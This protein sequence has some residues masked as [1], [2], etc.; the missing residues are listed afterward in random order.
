[1]SANKSFRI[2]CA[3]AA[4][5]AAGATSAWA[6]TSARE[7]ALNGVW[8]PA[9]AAG[10]ALLDVDGK[11]PPLNDAGKK[12][13]EQRS[14][15]LAKG[16]TSYD[17]SKKCKP[18]GFPRSLWDGSPFDLQVQPKLVFF[19]YTWN[20]NHRTA[21]FRDKLP[22]VQ[23]ARYYGLSAAHWDGNTLV[24]DSEGFNG[25]TLLDTKGLPHSEDMTL[26]ERYEPSADDKQ[27]KVRLTVTDPMYYSKPWD[28]V[29]TFNKVPDGRIKEDVCELH[30]KFYKGLF[31][32]ND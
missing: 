29:V 8:A 24:V 6:D 9:T 10:K 19:G 15:Q 25:N 14:A 4:L 31:P 18:I 12:L 13:Y 16:D 2:G 27:L 28:T 7:A 20:R 5:L 17:V 21:A 22:A 26:T 32:G 3:V 30:S 11:T 23:I 1:M